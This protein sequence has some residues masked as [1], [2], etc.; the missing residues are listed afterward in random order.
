MTVIAPSGER[1]SG[2]HAALPNHATSAPCTGPATSKVAMKT[3]PMMN[4]GT[5]IGSISS[6]WKTARPGKS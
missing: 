2:N 6:H 4:A 5:A 1:I 3:K